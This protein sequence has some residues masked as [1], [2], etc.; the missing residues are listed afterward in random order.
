MTNEEYQ[1]LIRLPGAEL[2]ER[3]IAAPP[4]AA[5]ASRAA[6]ADVADA[7]LPGAA[8]RPGRPRPGRAAARRF[9]AG[10]RRR[11]TGRRSLFAYT[12]KGWGL[13][14]AGDP[15]N[16]SALLTAEQIDEL[17]DRARRG[18]GR[19]VGRPSPPDSPEG[20]LCAGARPTPARTTRRRRRPPARRPGARA[21]ACDRC[22]H[23]S[24]QEALRRAADRAGAAPG[25]RRADRHRRA[26]R[27]RLDQPRRLD[28]PGRRLRAAAARRLRRRRPA[29]AALG[30][31]PDAASTSSS[32]SRE[33]NLFMLL[34]QL[35]L[36]ARA[37][38]PAA[39]PDR[40]ASTTRSSAAASTR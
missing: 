5:T 14:F 12:I 3:L 40:H 24:T 4:T 10:R 8:G 30:A 20:R 15:L 6:V 1:A 13:P 28:Q 36:S 27:L 11:R 37:G 33:M 21:S 34:G 32:A 7:D 9:A 18:P 2:R 19:R 26:R 25:G 16:H 38:R 22:R 35:G 29:P 23:S 39:L 31:G 17:R